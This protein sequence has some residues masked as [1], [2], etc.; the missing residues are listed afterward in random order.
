VRRHESPLVSGVQQVANHCLVPAFSATQIT[1]GFQ[2]VGSDVPIVSPSG[3]PARLNS[4]ATFGR[5]PASSLAII[6]AKL[7]ESV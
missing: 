1:A 3:K 7:G 5:R 4:H 2:P 6:F